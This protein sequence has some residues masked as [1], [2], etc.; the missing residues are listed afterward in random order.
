MYAP[1]M[2]AM[3]APVRR[4]GGD[5]AGVIT[6]A[7]PL[8]RLTVAR[9]QQLGQPLVEAARELAAAGTSSPLLRRDATRAA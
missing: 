7:G 9:M 8:Q 2:S 6:I 4:R 5:T 1:G 3:A